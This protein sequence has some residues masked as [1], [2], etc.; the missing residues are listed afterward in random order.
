MDLTNYEQTLKQRSASQKKGIHSYEHEI[1]AEICEYVN[2][3]HK[4]ALWLGIVKR[5][6]TAKMVGLLRQMKERNITSAKYLMACVK[7]K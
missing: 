6:G 1:T 2:E 3:P 5:V 4:F 7:K